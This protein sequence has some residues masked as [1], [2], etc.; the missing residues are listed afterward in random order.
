MQV[1]SL[2]S[3]TISVVA[4]IVMT[5]PAHA[6]GEGDDFDT[7]SDPVSYSLHDTPSHVDACS[8][9]VVHAYEALGINLDQ[10]V[11]RDMSEA[12]DDYP[13]DWGFAATGA[14]ENKVTNLAT[15]FKRHGYELPAGEYE[16]GDLVTWK[17]AGNHTHIGIVVADKSADG[18]PLVVHDAENGPTVE[19]VLGA[20]AVTGHYRFL[21]E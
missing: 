4:M 16:P 10:L 15:Y 8:D 13:D 5:G 21:P 12:R 6:L 17:A 18:T 9:L 2:L 1:K 20:Q 3:L 14:G 11:R 7:S 19:D